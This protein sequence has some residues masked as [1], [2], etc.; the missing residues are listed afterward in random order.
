MQ[1][2][3]AST[4]LSPGLSLAKAMAI[5]FVAGIIM[6]NCG[7]GGGGGEGNYSVWAADSHGRSPG[8]KDYG[9]SEHSSSCQDGH[10]GNY[11]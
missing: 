2:T 11:R 6:A 5:A 1:A 4:A 3:I 9:S 7:G 10:Q 8:D